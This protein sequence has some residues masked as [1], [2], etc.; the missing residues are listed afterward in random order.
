[1]HFFIPRALLA[2]LNILLNYD[3]EVRIVIP[4]EMLGQVHSIYTESRADVSSIDENR[5]LVFIIK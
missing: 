2:A 5:L 3:I 1:M 4:S